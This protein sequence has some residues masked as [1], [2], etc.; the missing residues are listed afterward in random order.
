MYPP[1]HYKNTVLSNKRSFRCEKKIKLYQSYK[2][3][4]TLLGKIQHLMTFLFQETDTQGYKIFHNL[5]L[6]TALLL[7]IEERYFLQIIN[8]NAT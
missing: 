7:C 5:E 8:L 1:I 4:Y 3:I 2:I 6:P